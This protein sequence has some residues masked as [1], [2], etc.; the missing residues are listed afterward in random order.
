MKNSLF[1]SVILILI[2]ACSPAKNTIGVDPLS[3]N[4]PSPCFA[5][6]FEKALYKASLDIKKQHMGGFLLIK[7]ISD[8]VHRIVFANEIGM[9]LFDLGFH[10]NQF[11]VYFV[12]EPL[13]KKILLRLFEKDFRQLIFDDKTG[14]LNLLMK[15]QFQSE[16][17]QGQV[18]LKITISNPGIKM[19][20]DLTLI[21]Q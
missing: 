2:Y 10:S 21:S 15:T 1:V 13:N 20:L 9:T 12:F 16:G 11:K 18:P 14:N 17:Q 6:T 7:K 5:G 4:S 8:S 19:K 3:G